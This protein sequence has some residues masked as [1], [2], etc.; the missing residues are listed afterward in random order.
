MLLFGLKGMLCSTGYLARPCSSGQSSQFCMRVQFYCILY[1]IYI[2]NKKERNYT[3]NFHDIILVTNHHLLLPSAG[4]LRCNEQPQLT[5]THNIWLRE[6]N[7]IVSQLA[8]INSHWDDERS[9]ISCSYLIK[10]ASRIGLVVRVLAL[11]SVG[12]RFKR[13]S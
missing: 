9:V 11:P 13:R 4:D 6:H 12:C 10:E 8:L 7:R 3:Y 2:Q 1:L 5:V